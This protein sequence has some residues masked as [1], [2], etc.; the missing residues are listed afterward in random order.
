[1]EIDLPDVEESGITQNSSLTLIDNAF[2]QLSIADPATADMVDTVKD[3][4]LPTYSRHQ[5]Q[6]SNIQNQHLSMRIRAP[7]SL[8]GGKRHPQRKRRVD[9]WRPKQVDQVD[10][11]GG[12]LDRGRSRRRHKV[13]HRQEQKQSRDTKLL[14]DPVTGKSAVTEEASIIT[15]PEKLVQLAKQEDITGSVVS[16]ALQPLSDPPP[17]ALPMEPFVLP[18]GSSYRVVHDSSKSERRVVEKNRQQA[19]KN[20]ETLLYVQS[21]QRKLD[22]L[23]R[24][25]MA[26]M[27]LSRWAILQLIALRLREEC[28]I[29]AGILTTVEEEEGIRLRG[30][31]VTSRR[32]QRASEL[33]KKV[34][35]FSRKLDDQESK[36]EMET[37]MDGL[38]EGVQ[39]L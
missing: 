16:R 20:D 5:S 7:S 33:A 3:Q 15:Q 24:P 11:P 37:E 1:M 21:L 23:N 19:E 26:D 38:V 4:K 14:L 9:S 13:H 22:A 30:I 27:T 8:G 2:V 39:R 35:E 29:A 10:M 18:P 36:M 28:E 6:R 25:Y 17:H 12:N 31:E 34:A 32:I